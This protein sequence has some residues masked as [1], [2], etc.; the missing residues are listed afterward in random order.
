MSTTTNI[1]QETTVLLSK[2]NPKKLFLF[3]FSA[4]VLTAMLLLWLPKTN[5]QSASIK[6]WIVSFLLLVA[7]F[8][9]LFQ[10][11][12]VITH[13]LADRKEALQSSPL[14][15][16]VIHIVYAIGACIVF[17]IAVTVIE[18]YGFGGA[19][20]FFYYERQAFIN[21]F[22]LIC[23][24]FLFLCFLGRI[25]IASLATG[26]FCFIFALVNIYK[27]QYRGEPLVPWDIYSVS[28]ALGVT[29]TLSLGLTALQTAL[30]I[31][32]FCMVLISFWIPPF[33]FKTRKSRFL[34]CVLYGAV[35][36]FCLQNY[37]TT[38]YFETN[39]WP[40]TWFRA[41]YF[42]KHGGFNSFLYN[43]RYL[44]MEKPVHYSK[45]TIE[46]IVTH[47]QDMETVTADTTQ[48]TSPTGQP[49]FAVSEKNPNIVVIMSE[50]LWN[51]AEIETLQFEEPLLPAFDKLADTAVSGKML[52]PK[53]GGGTSNVEF[54]ALTGFSNDYLPDGC[55]PYQQ[56]IREPF[57][58][59]AGYFKNKGY[60]T[61]AIHSDEGKNWNRKTAYPRM[62]FDDFISSEDFISPQIKR[63]RI[64]DQE[65][66]NRIISEYEKHKEK[67]TANP[68]FNF[69]VTMQ[70]HTGY[71]GS[72]F[73]E[74]E[75][76]KFHSKNTL[77]PEVEGQLS[78]YATGVHASDEALQYLLDYFSAVEEPTLVVIFGD[79]RTNLG[80]STN[81]IF[82]ETGYIDD[83][84]SETEKNEL[85]YTT[86]VAAWS[87]YKEVHMD[88]GTIA[89][90]QILPTILKNYG[91]E[92][93]KFF[94]FLDY[95]RT[96][97]T[98]SHKG[99]LLD[100]NG[101]SQ[102]EPI[103]EEQQK[104]YDMYQLLQYDYVL[105]EGY[106]TDTLFQ[107]EN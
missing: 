88:L 30:L 8:F 44:S 4:S 67:G 28:E 51:P 25:W 10:R 39:E 29:S 36:F 47:L 33:S 107:Y 16:A 66:T 69:T 86:P 79:H 80:N 82:Y 81:Q 52:S 62:G 102:K 72:N 1:N 45:S 12:A 96:V 42:S 6:S 106:S 37:I 83:T 48:T 84:M 31:F 75:K 23:L 58:S 32:I 87:N 63:G 19:Y 13:W 22:V 46:S 103:T 95:L 89:P 24:L 70:N 101:I 97:S 9:L 100:K 43:F 40:D 5:Q 14:K 60:D 18:H 11:T 53:F 68:W 56:Y 54:E 21:S 99:I 93:P 38:T 65:V 64:S 91:L 50:S 77:S 7:L 20:G 94:Q 73:T 74:A 90:Y 61:L 41:E 85:L 49:A 71:D 57:F 26:S 105:G 76:V 35:T 15:L 2:R 27:L 78:D 3:L 59:I 17:Q 98:G 34:S 92:K 55:I 104:L